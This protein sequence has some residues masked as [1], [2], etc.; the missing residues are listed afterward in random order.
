MGALT[1]EPS[2]LCHR[3][4]IPSISS[5]STMLARHKARKKLAFI[6]RVKYP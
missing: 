1:I 3:H 5:Y 6:H 2:I 4:A